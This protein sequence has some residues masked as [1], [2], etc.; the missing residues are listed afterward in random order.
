MPPTHDVVP[1]RLI[2]PS[3]RKTA[4]GT[5][6]P[7]YRPSPEPNAVCRYS[8]VAGVAFIRTF[9]FAPPPISRKESSYGAILWRNTRSTPPMSR[10]T[11]EPRLNATLVVRSG[12]ALGTLSSSDPVL[13]CSAMSLAQ[14]A[15]NAI[16]RPICCSGFSAENAQ[17]NVREGRQVNRTCGA[18][19]QISPAR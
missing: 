5:S 11:V 7:M 10:W 18:R 4:S 8:F 15:G 6:P 13:Y 12:M 16:A 19:S 1:I 9:T 2:E 14:H 17:L 3:L